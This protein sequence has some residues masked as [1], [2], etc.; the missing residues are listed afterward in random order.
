MIYSFLK[1]LIKLALKVYF[2]KIHIKG[3]ENIP[4]EGPLLIVAN[5]PSSFLDPICIALFTKH[6]ISFLAKGS[7]FE[8]KIIRS[9]LTGLNMIPIYRA[10]D[11]PRMLGK[12][13]QVFKSCYKK[14]ANK[15]VILIFPEG[16][17]ESERKLRK[18]K[19]GASRI[20]LGTVKENDLNLNV[21]ILPVGLNYTKSS[22]FRSE[23]FIQYGES[24]DSDNYLENYKT[25]EIK[26]AKTL[27]E[28]IEKSIKN[29]IIDIDKDEYEVLVERVES[30]YKK[31]IVKRQD[32]NDSF[33]D[34]KVSQEIYKGIKFFQEKDAPKFHRMKSKIDDYFLNLNEM[35]ISDRLM[36][37]GR[38][39]GNISLYLLKSITILMIG[40]PIWVFGYL[41]SFIPYKLP[42]YI[43]LK[44][45]NSDAFYGALLMSLGTFS[46]ILFYGLMI[47][48]SWLAFNSTSISLAYTIM[49][50]VSGF[51]TIFYARIARR[52][53]YNLKFLAKF[54]NKDKLMIELLSERDS[55][56]KE[57]EQL[58][59]LYKGSTL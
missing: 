37:N 48:F 49:L 25:D 27:T 38:Q 7:M 22:R 1:V 40:F 33:S 18:I 42:R 3:L 54:Y 11:N 43:A 12:N 32:Q 51:F 29:L 6:K 19:T 44:I 28:N 10:Q 5:H 8:N 45:S 41:N 46:F 56:K 2:R 14:L 58:R 35:N 24:L 52:M 55:I 21:K 4:K 50:P 16:T 34:I 26:T 9:I 23:V 53:F 31:D 17:S 36:E 47:F 59:I 30:L 13:H 57:L 15:G 39:Q 20:A